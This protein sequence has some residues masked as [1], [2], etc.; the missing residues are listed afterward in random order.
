MRARGGARTQLK[1]ERG[2]L[3]TVRPH[4]EATINVGLEAGKPKSVSPPWWSAQGDIFSETLA[5]PLSAAD[6]AMMAGL[7]AE[8]IPRPPLVGANAP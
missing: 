7:F 2:T 6:V 8:G 4:W 1:Q 3:G 5:R